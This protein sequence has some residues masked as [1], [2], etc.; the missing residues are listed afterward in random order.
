MAQAQARPTQCFTFT[1]ILKECK[2]MDLQVLSFVIETGD[3]GLFIPT[4]LGLW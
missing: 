3:A 1:S 2:Y 4:Q